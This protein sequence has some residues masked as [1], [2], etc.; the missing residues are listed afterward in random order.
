MKKLIMLFIISFGSITISGQVAVNDDGSQA[1]GSAI[2]DVKSSTKGF[3]PPRLSNGTILSMSGPAEGLLVYNSTSKELN[4]YNGSNWVDM[5]GNVVLPL[6]GDF[7]QGGVVFYVDGAGGGY[8]CAVSDQSSGA[9]WGCNGTFISGADG[10]AMGTG[11]Q[12]TA[13]IEA[14]CSTSGIA[15]DI[16]ANL[17]LNGY[18]DWF[19]PSKDEL[20]QMY[21]NKTTID[22]TAQMNGGSAFAEDFYWSSSETGLTN[23]WRQDFSNGNQYDYYAKDNMD[24]VR[25]IRSF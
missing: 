15:A 7:Y 25:A 18:D 13:D 24:N 8:V 19:L 10:T 3:L 16:C 22:V 11:A 2:L 5:S 17:S 23:A 6:V 4:L 21:Q 20:N 14:G 12:N 9:K 1:D